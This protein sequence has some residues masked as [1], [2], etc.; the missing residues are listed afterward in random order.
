MK[1]M[2]VFNRISKLISFHI[3]RIKRHFDDAHI[4]YTSKQRRVRTWLIS[5]GTKIVGLDG[6]TGQ[7]ESTVSLFSIQLQI[8]FVISLCH[9]HRP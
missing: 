7:R 3:A 4:R 9:G 2:N 8:N 6:D 5:L 1:F